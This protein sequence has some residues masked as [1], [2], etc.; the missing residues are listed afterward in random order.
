MHRTKP[1]DVLTAVL[2]VRAGAGREPG[3]NDDRRARR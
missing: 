1:H 3:A 2:G